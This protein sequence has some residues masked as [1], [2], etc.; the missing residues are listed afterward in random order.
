MNCEETGK[1]KYTPLKNWQY[2]TIKSGLGL[3]LLRFTSYTHV[4][5]FCKGEKKNTSSLV[6]ILLYWQNELHPTQKLTIE[7]IKTA[8]KIVKCG[9][10]LSLLRFVS[11]T[12]VFIFC[13]GGT[14]PF[15]ST[16]I[17]EELQSISTPLFA[18]ITVLSLCG[19]LFAVCLFA[20]N[21]VYRNNRWVYDM[22]Q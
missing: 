19:S 20:F 9:L 22:V 6:K 1:N 8:I 13:K 3:S 16:Q 5:I 10:G 11:N 14:A 17:L 15:D 18:I 4:L 12:H 21:I 7:I 2:L